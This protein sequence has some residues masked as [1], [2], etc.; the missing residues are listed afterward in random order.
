MIRKLFPVPKLI[1]TLALIFVVVTPAQADDN[2]PPVIDEDTGA[3]AGQLVALF[4][5]G[6]PEEEVLQ[7]AAQAGATLLEYDAATGAALFELPSEVRADMVAADQF[8]DADSSIL[9][10]G[11]NYVYTVGPVD[12]AREVPDG[13]PQK[14]YQ[15]MMFD[16]TTRQRVLVEVTPPP[17]GA[18]V[19]SSSWV[20]DP[21]DWLQWGWVFIDMDAMWK[22]K[23]KGAGVHIL[24]T[25]TD[26]KHPD[27]KGIKAGY[28]WIN[29][30]K[31]AT[32]DYGHGT[33]VAGI[34]AAKVNNKIGIPGIVGSGAVYSSKVIT[35]Q[36]LAQGPYGMSFDVFRG[37]VEAADNT[38]IRIINMSLGQPWDDPIVLF[39]IQ[40]AIAQDK[41]L[42]I[43]A[44]N[45]AEL[46]D[47]STHEAYPA[48]YVARP[49]EDVGDINGDGLSDYIDYYE[50]IIVVGATGWD[51]DDDDYIWGWD[52][53]TCKA[54]YSNYGGYV[55]MYAPGTWIY[56][57]LPTRPN[58]NWEFEYGS[59]SGTSMAAPHVT[60]VASLV[61]GQHPTWTAWDVKQQLLY[62]DQGMNGDCIDPA[63]ERPML[64]AAGATETAALEGYVY[65][66]YTGA[67][68]PNAK[69]EVRALIGGRTTSLGSDTI[70]KE[71]WCQYYQA[72]N[73]PLGDWSYPV[74][75]Y[76]N[77][78]GHTNGS[79]RYYSGYWH[80]PGWN[81]VSRMAL[82]P[83]VS[84]WS[85][86]TA[87]LDDWYNLDAYLF[88]PAGYYWWVG[89]WP[90]DGVT[91][92][93]PWLWGDL[94][95]DPYTRVMHESEMGWP[96]F[97]AIGLEQ[98]NQYKNGYPYTFL[99]A[100]NFYDLDGSPGTD[101]V[102]DVDGC[103]YVWN[104]GALAHAVCRD[105]YGM[106][107]SLPPETGE[108]YW[109]IG[110][111]VDGIYYPIDTYTN[112][113]ISYTGWSFDEP[114]V[115]G[116]GTGAPVPT[117]D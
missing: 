100:Q 47:C 66:A 5:G 17:A 30:K 76:V 55:D 35:S 2:L 107:G 11:P 112:D 68:V 24:D 28:D 62:W 83:K 32:D 7:A 58:T 4:K 42:V 26:T 45:D 117:G 87:E 103:A 80:W 74:D 36:G 13:P 59:M 22:N 64:W 61:W 40:Y 72:L 12:V 94:V 116:D 50:H 21:Y 102:A 51:L 70:C 27:L 82:P 84:H 88:I 95:E 37:L 73:I 63:D 78:K 89:P 15:R 19:D 54:G 53:A 96:P 60:G 31:G 9:T 48:C 77:E 10:A 33:H 111:V 1:L 115:A 43:S 105:W 106:Y 93:H 75:I 14:P 56:S 8:M 113:Y 44:G 20:S 98:S 69:V 108:K 97:D 71:S 49:P 18:N 39:G 109:I 81:W 92:S 57:T 38:A 104:N 29:D 23:I 65:D 101:P 79:Q 91:A 34:I 110:Q 99:V 46:L 25:G 90:P 52:E 16:M 6:T 3:V 67:G 41:L 85:F 114:F 86:V